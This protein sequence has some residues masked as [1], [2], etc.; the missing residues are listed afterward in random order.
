MHAY[1]IMAHSNFG[2]L[3]K[4]ITMLDA[5]CNDIYIHIDKRVKNFDFEYYKNLAKYS[6]V[7]F[8]ERICVVWGD[9]SMVNAEYILLK[10]AYENP[11]EYKYYHLI[12]GVD[13]PLKTA[14]E[15]ADFF[16]KAYPKEF[17]H[18]SKG[19]NPVEESRIK[20]Y[21]F[22]TGRRNIFNRIATKTEQ[23]LQTALRIDR[24]RGGRIA[25]G[26]QWFSITDKFAGYLMQN[27]E[28]IKK[29]MK[30][31]FIPDEFFVQCAAVN[32]EFADNLYVGRFDDSCEQNMRYID[33]TR[34]NPYTFCES[35]F[36]EVMNSGK[37]FARKLTEENCLP[38]MIFEAV[39]DKNCTKNKKNN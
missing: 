8:T 6:R 21:H 29:R 25:R 27:E 14:E 34:G 5:S 33:W 22:F 31:T 36:D 9:I 18:F 16:D 7:C 26:S 1:L 24:T 19:M 3:E 23:L 38:K 12:S 10:K 20:H 4:L 2:I 35:D 11:T 30:F 32:S 37:L 13:L 15:L 17:I 28:K 39:Y